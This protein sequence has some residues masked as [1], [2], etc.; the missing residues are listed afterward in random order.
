MILV[1]PPQNPVR[2]DVTSPQNLARPPC[3]PSPKSCGPPHVRP[4]VRL[5]LRT[6][7]HPPPTARSSPSNP[8]PPQ[9]AR[10]P[11]RPIPPP[12]PRHTR[13]FKSVVEVLYS[14]CAHKVRE[15]LLGP[16]ES[17]R[18]HVVIPRGGELRRVPAVRD[19]RLGRLV[20][21]L[22]EQGEPLEEVVLARG[23]IRRDPY[24]QARA[25]ESPWEG[26]DLDADS[27]AADSNATGHLSQL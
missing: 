19:P 18:L 21:L 16:A 17:L 8:P 11:P 13:M 1:R 27:D 15:D 20:H 7:H 2:G 25:R 9:R 24:A 5:N 22:D 4:R 14:L 3:P 23:H 12:R 6:P 10:A 26:V